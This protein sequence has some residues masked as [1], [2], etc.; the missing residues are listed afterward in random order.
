[1][2]FLLDDNVPLS[3]IYA[4]KA[5]EVGL[6]GADD[7][8]V[9]RYAIDNDFKII[10]LD[11]DFGYLFLKF[12]KGTVIVLRPNKAYTQQDRKSLRKISIQR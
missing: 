7:E 5:I 4:V 12:Q 2:K 10:T 3:V 1:M 9:Y 6:D 11:L 8:T